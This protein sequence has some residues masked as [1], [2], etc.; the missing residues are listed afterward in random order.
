MA[1][2]LKQ[3]RLARRIRMAE[4]G[5]QG[6]TVIGAL[7]VFIAASIWLGAI[8]QRR[9]EKKAF[10]SGYFLG[11][12]GLGAWT[13]ALTAT[14]QSGGTFMGFPALIYSHG[15]IVALWIAGYM[16]VPLSGFAIVGKRLA[17]LSRRSGAITVP[18]MFRERF[19]NAHIGLIASLLILVFMSTMMVAQFKAGAI[20]MKLAWPGNGPMVLTDEN[21]AALD[22]AEI[23]R[24]Q[25]IESDAKAGE[26]SQAA[27]KPAEPTTKP[28]SK[29]DWAYLIGLG[30]FALTV[31]GYTLIGGFLAS[32]WSDLFQS[33][34]MVIG[35]MILLCLVLPAAGGLEKATHTAVSVTGPGFA[36]G[37]GYQAGAGNA[38]RQFLTPG[39]GVSFFLIWVLAG[40][41]S[42]ASMVR[43]MATESTEVLRKSVFLLSCYNCL[44][45][46]PLIM[47]VISA[48]SLIPHLDNPDEIV[49]RLALMMTS[50]I[51]F[52]GLLSGLIL[53]APFGAVMATVSCYLLV[54]A[55]GLVK[56][57]YLR[58][59]NPQA[60]EAQVK[61][62]TYAVM[63]VVGL[64]AIAANI[65]P[66]KYLQALV[67]LSGSS[68]AATFVVP[69][70]MLCYWRRASAAGAMAAMLAGA[71][72]M[73]G[74]YACGWMQRSAYAG[75]SSAEATG[76]FGPFASLIGPP[77][78]IGIGGDFDPLFLLGLD[79]II[80]SLTASAIAGIVVTLM[81][82]PPEASRVARFFEPASRLKPEAEPVI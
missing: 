17:Q 10:L 43:V 51:P 13:M 28:V 38:S 75:G 54:I 39:L 22:A 23:A 82:N 80:W 72:G 5:A 4:T 65:Q 55:S 9:I 40:V 56:D 21:P 25:G 66:V 14:V 70:V 52:G 45:Y 41:G 64:L 63:I 44:I 31:V 67:V 53:A 6:Y 30:V 59:L 62:V 29:T 57:I 47:I 58:F 77:A 32:V 12:R 3:I 15:W 36:T 46:F 34:M 78:N 1:N 33:V 27:T 48:R 11:N 49:P 7:L 24:E 61:R 16:I 69:A 35:V 79:P 18:D 76:F 68:A 26:K 60:G 74:L 2:L 71:G 8:A 19:N 50:N 73:F 20:V 37:P 81:T 42:P